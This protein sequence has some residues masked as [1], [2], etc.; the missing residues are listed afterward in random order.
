MSKKQKE[1]KS[2][3]LLARLARGAAYV[4]PMMMTLGAL[5]L[6]GTHIGEATV[7]AQGRSAGKV[8]VCHVNGQGI[9][10]MISISANALSAHLGHGDYLPIGGTCEVGET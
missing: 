6:S 1:S 2:R 5:T 7:H 4:P 9:P 10:N 3:L 8:D